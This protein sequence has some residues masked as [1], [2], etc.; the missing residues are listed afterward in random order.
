MLTANGDPWEGWRTAHGPDGLARPRHHRPQRAA[1][2]A[3]TAAAMDARAL[4]EAQEK[5]KDRLDDW[6]RTFVVTVD[7][8]VPMAAVLGAGCS[9]G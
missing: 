6:V 1:Y 9:Y 8:V 2:D 5:R 3:A 4:E 7:Y